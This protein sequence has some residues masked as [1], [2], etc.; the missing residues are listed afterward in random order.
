MQDKKY[1]ILIDQE[2]G[3]VSRLNKIID[4]SMFSQDFFGRLYAKDKKLLTNYYKI[5]IDTVAG[6]LKSVGI[7][8]NTVPV[9]DV[10]RKNAHNVIGTRSFS[11]NQSHVSKIGSLC[12][13]FYEKNKIGT[14]FKHI[15]GHGFT[16]SDSH[17]KRPII[18]LNKKNLIK[19]DFKPFKFCKF[20]P[21]KLD[22]RTT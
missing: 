12:I 10:R 20:Y 14:V 16:K 11:K 7:N 6:I 9:L 17:Y 19:K 4:L 21:D 13:K 1:P 22:G 15:P 2:G 18:K 8:I 5:Y 3:K